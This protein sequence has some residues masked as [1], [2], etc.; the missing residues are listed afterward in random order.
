MQVTVCDV[1]G[2]KMDN[3]PLSVRMGEKEYMIR[4]VAD[5]H[6]SSRHADICWDCATKAWEKR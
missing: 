2:E 6:G 5:Q 4:I 3:T 1:C